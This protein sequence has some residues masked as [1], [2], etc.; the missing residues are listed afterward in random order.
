MDLEKIFANHIWLKWKRL[1]IRR[2][3]QDKKQL[4]LSH[5]HM[6]CNMVQLVW[7]TVQLFLTKLKLYLPYE[8]V[9][10]LLYIYL[11]EMKT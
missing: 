5:P 9:V 1:T 8:S 10:T 6:E 3:G 2:V 4:E 7:K 11:R